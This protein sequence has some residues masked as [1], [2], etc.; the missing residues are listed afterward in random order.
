M[1]MLLCARLVMLVMLV[2]PVNIG[3]RFLT[4]TCTMQLCMSVGIFYRKS[5]QIS[6]LLLQVVIGVG[7]KIL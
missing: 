7:A 4:R 1:I 5:L 3:C 2:M 6:I